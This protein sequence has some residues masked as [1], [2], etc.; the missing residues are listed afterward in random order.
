M[1]YTDR[2]LRAWSRTLPWF[3][4]RDIRLLPDD[5]VIYAYRKYR[6]RATRELV[7]RAWSAWRFRALTRLRQRR[8]ANWEGY[9]RWF[10]DWDHWY[11]SALFYG[12][13]KSAQV[14]FYD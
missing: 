8:V 10:H 11:K 7:Y 1:V 6:I 2:R 14:V 5:A 12:L 9:N 13:S 4:G 3:F